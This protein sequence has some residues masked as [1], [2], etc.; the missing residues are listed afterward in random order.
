MTL[1]ELLRLLR[2]NL[3]LVVILP[4]VFA[5]IM[6][7]YSIVAMVDNYTAEVSIY[8]LYKNENNGTGQ[9]VTYSDLN[10][11]QMLANDF[12]ELADDGQVQNKV[13]Q[14]LGMEDLDDYKVSIN[15]STTSRVIKIDVTGADPERTAAVA[16]ALA[17]VVGDTAVDVM[18]LDAVNVISQAETPEVPSGPNRLMYVAIAFLA[19]LFIAVAIVVVRDMLNTTL[20]S[21]EE[22][23]ELLGVPV[24]G[25]Y[26]YVKSKGGR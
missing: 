15:S 4:V 5:L 12:V 8:A 25:R 10:A 23:E 17:K 1:L 3:K 18:S 24:I 16:N 7:S 9:D 6:C 14:M 20:R 26:P 22:A 13:A 19:G 11:S 21:D 2:S